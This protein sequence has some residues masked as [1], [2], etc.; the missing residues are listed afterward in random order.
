MR[1]KYLYI[2]SEIEARLLLLP[3]CLFVSLSLHAQSAFDLITSNLNISASNYCIYPDS[4]FVPMTPP[5][6]GKHPFYISHYGRHGSRYLSNRKG[7][8]TPYK[9]LCKAD[10]ADMLTPVG[11]MVMLE[12]QG[13][14]ADAEGRWGDLTGIGKQQQR[15]IAQ[16]MIERFPEV[17]RDGAF[18]D[19]RSTIINRCIL[20]MGSAVLQMAKLNPH[21]RFSMNSSYNDMW[22]MNYQDKLLRS[23]TIPPKAK[24]AYDT[25]CQPRNRNPRL[26]SL[27]FTDSVYASKEMDEVW[28]N[29]YLLKAAIIQ[30]NTH[31][32]RE[33]NHLIDLFS[34]EDIHQFWQKENAWWY[35]MY[36][37]SPLNGDGKKPYTQRYLL[38]RIIQ[39]ADSVMRLDTY[40][41]S[42]R[43]GH[44]TIVL[45][46][47]C[48]LGLN[49]FD[50]QTAN[51]EELESKG[52]WACLV[53]PM[54][55][56]I[57]FVFYRENP[58]DED[59]IF[60]MLLNENEATLPI[61]T[62]I[63]PYYH[64]RDFRKHYLRKLD[65]YEKTR[66]E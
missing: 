6:P 61:P 12:M 42:L 65:E 48:L 35:I 53:L 50:Y 46:L 3:F 21:L 40:G 57:Q 2:L 39:E 27:L 28:L 17:F 4:D 45:P 5:P 13:I 33:K 59:V 10:S 36:G 9:L 47:V 58:Q 8:D 15:N 20:S 11:K 34:Y 49:G 51:L 1:V 62:D 41:A 7:Y 18:V 64:W 56:N 16:R 66:V 60:K 43:F 14:I 22:Y 26:M 55:S 23:N 19:A 31:K 29:Y 24:K 30:Q 63:A 25:F 38:R 52:W 32:S 54:A 37:S 44:E